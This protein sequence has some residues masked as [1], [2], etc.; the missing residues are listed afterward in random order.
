MD[1]WS[2]VACS[3]CGRVLF[4]KDGP[5]C[6]ECL[7]KLAQDKKEARQE[8]KAEPKEKAES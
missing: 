6:P 2:A 8:A 1:K 5:T 3:E 4:A 7:A